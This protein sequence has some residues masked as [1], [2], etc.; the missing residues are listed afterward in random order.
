MDLFT[1]PTHLHLID[2]LVDLHAQQ[3]RVTV[4]KNIDPGT[5][6][7]VSVGD[8]V[9]SNMGSPRRPIDDV[10]AKEI[11]RLK[12]QIE[13][14]KKEI[15]EGEEMVKRLNEE[16]DQLSHRT[17]VQERKLTEME[18]RL[19]EVNVRLKDSDTRLHEA[20]TKHTEVAMAATRASEEREREREGET[21]PAPVPVPVAEYEEAIRNLQGRVTALDEIID[22]NE[23]K[24]SNMTTA[25]L[26][27]SALIREKSESIEKI[28]GLF[29]SLQ[30]QA[31]SCLSVM[32]TTVLGRLDA[33]Q[34]EVL[35]YLSRADEL[36]NELST[37]SLQRNMLSEDVTKISSELETLKGA[38]QVVEFELAT[39]N[40]KLQ[41]QSSGGSKE[42][43]GLNEKVAELTQD[44][45]SATRKIYQLEK[46]AELVIQLTAKVATG[47]HEFLHILQ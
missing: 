4:I 24:Y 10:N 21:A 34:S 17:S 9:G 13:L 2:R 36:E 47:L 22:I 35:Q 19:N 44:L 27:F 25:V 16:K 37:S 15:K 39:A 46:G 32:G 6:Q 28:N 12:A 14:Q 23:T 45:A 3:K 29:E 20:L 41:S 31:K 42:V 33:M 30:E 7:S 40:S 1:L 5:P 11:A 26:N 38:Y 18:C 8:L 43:D